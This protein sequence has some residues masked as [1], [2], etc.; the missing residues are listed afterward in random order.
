M[1]KTMRSVA[2]IGDGKVE[3]VRD[4]P[5][6]EIGPYESLVKVRTCGFCSGTDFH[7]IRGQMAVDVD[8]FPS[9]IGHEGIGDIVETGSKVRYY[10]VGDRFMNPV[11]KLMPGTRYGFTWGAMSDYCIVEDQKAM[12]EDGLGDQLNPWQGATRQIPNDFDVEDGGVLL[13]LNECF[14]A[15]KN[16]NVKDQDVLVYGCGPMGLATMKYMRYL[17]AKTITAVDSVDERLAL[18]KSLSGVDETINFATEDKDYI[19]KDRLFDRVIDI[20][21]L[22]SILMEG[23]HRLRPYGIVGSMGVLKNTDAVLDVTKL[24]NNTL[25]QM[26]NFPYG[27]YDITYENIELMKKGVINPKDFYSHV[28]S[29]EDIQ[30]VLRLVET[31]EAIK[32]V[33][34][35]D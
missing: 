17:G 18:A 20:V 14:S 12:I 27:Q 4:V 15:A 8:P 31:K 25:L 10:K 35:F 32:V 30:E 6:P 24:K 26:L 16:F 19:L 21:G 3:L 9:L 23:S 7:I 2:A 22:S 28:K 29:V 1:A 11:F 34:K 33:V 5:I 13:T